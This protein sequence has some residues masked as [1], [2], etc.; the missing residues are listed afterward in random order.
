M[1]AGLTGVHMAIVV[2]HV[3]LDKDT[4]RDHAHRQNHRGMDPIALE[5]HLRQQDV[6]LP[7]AVGDFNILLLFQ[8]FIIRQQPQQYFSVK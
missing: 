1:E 3:A 4:E 2:S 6:H 8:Y 7:L 5:A